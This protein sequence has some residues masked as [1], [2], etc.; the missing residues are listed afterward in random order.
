ME[1]AIEKLK[2]EMDQDKDNAF[3]QAV[4]N[5]LIEYVN[6]NPDKAQTFLAEDKTIAGSLQK[7][8]ESA[9]K[10]A[11][12]GC[13]VLTDEEAY[14]VVLKYF[15]IESLNSAPA[16]TQVQTNSLNLSLDELFG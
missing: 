11:K 15:G 7:M 10:Q 2:N 1:K 3:L 14:K 4:G 6:R 9:R 12:N 13:A 16:A 5:Y 8:K